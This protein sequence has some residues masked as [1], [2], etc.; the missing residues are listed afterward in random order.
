VVKYEPV[1]DVFIE[2]LG[3]K[4]GATAKVVASPTSV[5]TIGHAF[6]NSVVMLGRAILPL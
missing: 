3:S 1:V 2:E 4:G 6:V 5:V